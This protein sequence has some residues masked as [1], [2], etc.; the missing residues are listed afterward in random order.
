VT[1]QTIPQNTVIACLTPPSTGAIAVLAVH[2]SDAWRVVSKLFQRH[3]PRLAAL[4]DSPTI[5]RFW[6]GRMG[7]GASDEILLA[8]RNLQPIPWLE[9]HVHGGQEVLRWIL[10]IFE[11]AGISS[12]GWRDFLKCTSD[13]ALTANAWTALSDAPTV[14]TASI[15]LDQVHGALCRALTAI[16]ETIA[17]NS[18][19]EGET[20]VADLMRYESLGRHLTTPWKVAIAGAPN[21]GKSSL[22]N[23]LAGFQRSIVAPTPGTT[24]DVVWTRIAIDGWSLEI[25]DTAGLR[26]ATDQLETSGVHLAQ[27]AAASADLCIWVLDG[28]DVPVWPDHV[29]ANLLIVI[30]KTDLTPAWN[31]TEADGATRVS[32]RTG[33]GFADLQKAISNRLVPDVPPPGAAVPLNAHFCDGLRQIERHVLEKNGA[34]AS[35]LLDAMRRESLD[36]S[37]ENNDADGV[38]E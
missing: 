15:V 24:R 2:G 29:C 7:D 17:E 30:N 37:E 25:A 28:S 35:Q 12:R 34:K 14:R 10:E 38:A 11:K 3:F 26:V 20:A 19:D 21:V 27:D 8:V 1:A 13:N 32:A 18:W 23:A 4:P 5:G 22:L 33:A 9:L 6:L 16:A 36:S 31:F